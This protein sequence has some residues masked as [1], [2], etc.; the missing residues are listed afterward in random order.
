MAQSLY[1]DR[2]AETTATTGTGTVTLAGAISSQYE[3]FSSAFADGTRV[4]YAIFGAAG[5]E[6]GQGVFASGADTLSRLTVYA[7]SNSNAL[8]SLTGTSTVVSTLPASAIAD[9]GLTAAMAAG[10]V[11]Q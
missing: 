4:D 1:A 7:S 6:I 8:V 9:K 5:W 2:V 10:T 11:P 3:T